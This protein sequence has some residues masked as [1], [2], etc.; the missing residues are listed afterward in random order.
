MNHKMRAGDFSVASA[1][2]T[3]FIMLMGNVKCINR[4]QEK[5]SRDYS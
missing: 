3:T 1:L 5:I 2:K 4:K